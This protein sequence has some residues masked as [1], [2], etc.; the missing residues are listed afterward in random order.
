MFCENC[1]STLCEESKFCVNC[2]AKIET[3]QSGQAEAASQIP[4]QPASPAP[5]YAPPPAYTPPAYTPPAY[6]PPVQAPPVY[7][8]QVSPGTE[9][10]RV[11]QCIGMLLLMCVPV[12]N[13]ILLFK[14]SFGDS[15]NLNKKNY[16]RAFLILF[17]V[18]IIIWI[19]AGAA[20][21]SMIT[22]II[23]GMGGY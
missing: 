10:L 4:V 14:W 8:S 22:E 19:I 11:G 7:P 20:L 5:A 6:V 9:V 2:G 23:D 15:V 17:V 18:V 1:G 21:G 13:I 12:L 3:Q 16:A